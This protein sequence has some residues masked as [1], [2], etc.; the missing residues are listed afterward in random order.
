[1]H[2]NNHA[3][4]HV[5]HGN[6]VGPVHHHL[7]PKARHHMISINYEPEK[8]MEVYGEFW[9]YH[10]ER[11]ANEPPEMKLLFALQMGFSVQVNTEIMA[12]M[13]ARHSEEPE[14]KFGNPALDPCS[15]E[16][17]MQL[18]ANSVLIDKSDVEVILKHC[19]EGVVAIIIA[20]TKSA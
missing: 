18:I 9:P 7:G 11:V 16:D 14:F 6:G 12:A 5:N 4:H 8:L 2:I 19:P 15:E 13:K 20:V 10:I 17:I 1:M 3:P